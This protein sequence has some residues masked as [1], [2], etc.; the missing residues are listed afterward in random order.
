MWRGKEKSGEE[1]RTREERRLWVTVCSV[2]LNATLD[3][4]QRV[5]PQ[6]ATRGAWFWGRSK[7]NCRLVVFDF[8]D[9][10]W[11]H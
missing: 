5:I 1:R 2:S 4:L 8:P 10:N 7:A 11:L 6:A 9:S 3:Y